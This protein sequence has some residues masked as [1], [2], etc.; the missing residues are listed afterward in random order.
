MAG[1]AGRLT[2]TA[3]AD[4]GRVRRAAGAAADAVSASGLQRTRL[5]TAASELARNTLIHGGGGDVTITTARN[6]DRSQ[7]VGFEVV[8]TFTDAGPG[9]PDVE[10]A[11]A[12]G[13]ST[14]GGMGLG[15]G[16]ARRLCDGFSVAARPG[17]GTVVRIAMRVRCR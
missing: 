12:D 7:G 15:L 3:E 2:I 1:E 4:I 14:G 8:L 11:L 16:G 5:V 13:F 9:I 10:Q 17:G 6:A